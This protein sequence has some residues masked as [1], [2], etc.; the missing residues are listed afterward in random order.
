MRDQG[1]RRWF[2]VNTAAVF[3]A[4]TERAEVAP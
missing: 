3:V 1:N 2:F 4:A